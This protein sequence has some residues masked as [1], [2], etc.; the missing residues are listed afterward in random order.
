MESCIFVFITSP[1]GS[2]T[3][4][5]CLFY[6]PYFVVAFGQK[7]YSLDLPRENG[8][9]QVTE[10]PWQCKQTAVIQT[11]AALRLESPLKAVICRIKLQ[12]GFVW[13]LSG[14]CALGQKRR[15]LCPATK[16]CCA[17]TSG[18]GLLMEPFS[19]IELGQ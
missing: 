7:L 5:M 3:L 15:S 18:Q 17:N 9:R 16:G 4:I 1:Y 2:L 13:V 14:L 19:A 10:N 6:L 12:I 8:Y 11:A